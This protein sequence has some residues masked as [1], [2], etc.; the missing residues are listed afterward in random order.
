MCKTPFLIYL[1]IHSPSFNCETKTKRQRRLWKKKIS[2]RKGNDV[3][4]WYPFFKDDIGNFFW[5]V[6]ICGLFNRYL[7]QN[8]FCI[9]SFS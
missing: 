9:R 7:W 1:V 3:L 4:K 8:I 5:C 6:Y 2:V